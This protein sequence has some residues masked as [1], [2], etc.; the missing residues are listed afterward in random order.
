MGRC[1]YTCT[2]VEN[3]NTLFEQTE[4][5]EGRVAKLIRWKGWLDKHFERFNDA[6]RERAE[7]RVRTAT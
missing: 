4:T 3:G 6:I 5:Y 7:E 2:A 1:C